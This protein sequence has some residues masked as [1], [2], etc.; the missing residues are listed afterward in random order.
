MV[1]PH[2]DC[3]VGFPR[4]GL[5]AEWQLDSPQVQADSCRQRP[6]AALRI[7]ERIQVPAS[8]YEW[9]ATKPAGNGP[10]PFRWRTAASFKRHFLRV[11]PY[12]ALSGMRKEM[13]SSNWGIH[14]SS[15][16][17]LPRGTRKIMKIDAIILR[18]L[19]LPLVRPFETSFG[20]TTQPQNPSGRSAVRRADRLGRVHGR[21]ASV[22]LRGIDRQRLA[23]DRE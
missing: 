11:W 15:E 9:K 16:A 3:R 2:L 23:G 18:E 20:V 19:H 1:Y 5:L 7:E 22:F 12:S 17:S 6:A 4:T 14:P 21:R 13:E 8:I 10:S